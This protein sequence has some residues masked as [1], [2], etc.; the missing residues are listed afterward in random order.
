[1]RRCQAPS[2]PRD[3]NHHSSEFATGHERPLEAPWLKLHAPNNWFKRFPLTNKQKKQANSI[4]NDS[5][6]IKCLILSIQ[7]LGLWHTNHI[8]RTHELPGLRDQGLLLFQLPM[9]ILLDRKSRGLATFERHEWPVMSLMT[10]VLLCEAVK[11]YSRLEVSIL[12]RWKMDAVVMGKKGSSTNRS[13]QS[14]C[15]HASRFWSAPCTSGQEKVSTTDIH[16]LRMV[17]VGSC[18]PFKG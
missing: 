13:I 15:I 8:W 17:H 16:L 18:D 12:G 2:V 10:S 11:R 9:K 5:N 3:P 7:K 14:Y 6:C 1:M 4:A